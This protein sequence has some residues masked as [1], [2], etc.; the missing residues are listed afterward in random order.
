MQER[1]RDLSEDESN[2]KYVFSLMHIHARDVGLT[3][4]LNCYEIFLPLGGFT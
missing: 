2:H 1:L 3:S 4:A